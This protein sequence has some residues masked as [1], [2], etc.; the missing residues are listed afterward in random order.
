MSRLMSLAPTTLAAISLLAAP[1]QSQDKNTTPIDANS[2]VTRCLGNLIKAD[3][4]GFRASTKGAGTIGGA[5]TIIRQVQGQQQ[6]AEPPVDVTE[7]VRIG[8]TLLWTRNEGETVL[9][10]RGRVWVTRDRDGNW[11]PGRRPLGEWKSQFLPDPEF[12]A[13]GLLHVTKNVKWEFAGPDEIDEKPVRLYK[14]VLENDEAKYL[15][16]TR[17]LPESGAVGGGMARVVF[18]G[19]G[20]QKV[21]IPE[22]KAK[23]EVRVYED[24]ARRMPLRITADVWVKS[25]LAG[26][27]VE[28]TSPRRFFHFAR[29]LPHQGAEHG[30]ALA[31]RRDQ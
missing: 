30:E 16:R 22:P 31:L 7:G 6:N 28:E 10:N 8:S 5:I 23:I 11:I 14:V 1:S 29:I 4:Y 25:P 15:M 26:E 24:P 19:G 20:G 27:Q 17:T 18:I 21:N 9:A 2:R 3:N 12:L 13:K